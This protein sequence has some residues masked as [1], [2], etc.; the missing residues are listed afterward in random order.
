M[1]TPDKVYENKHS[2]TFEFTFRGYFLKITVVNELY[3]DTVLLVD[4]KICPKALYPYPIIR[5]N[6]I[7]K[8][9]EGGF[10]SFYELTEKN[11]DD[12]LQG[13]ENAH[14]FIKEANEIVKSILS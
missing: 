3:H 14:E 7:T 2:K 11:K 13:I 6:V 12:W 9:F 10:N 1:R 8:E 4:V 5:Y